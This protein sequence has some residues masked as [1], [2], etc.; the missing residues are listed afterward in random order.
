MAVSYTLQTATSGLFTVT[1]NTTDYWDP[2]G[3]DNIVNDDYNAFT[4]GAFS[5]SATVLTNGHLV[6]GTV[7]LSCTG[8]VY[9]PSYSFQILP[10]G[11]LLQGNLTAFGFQ[12]GSEETGYSEFD[13]EFNVTGGELASVYGSE[14][15]ALLSTQDF[16][17][18]GSFAANFNTDA[19]GNEGNADTWMMVP[20]PEPFFLVILSVLGLCWVARWRAPLRKG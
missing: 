6:S 2:S 19:S 15:G 14:A 16:S 13:Y 7:S 11:T 17:F 9:D 1:G 20:E 5:L 10:A 18:N 12:G 8:G 3:N 4:P